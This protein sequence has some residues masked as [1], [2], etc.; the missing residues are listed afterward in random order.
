M[1]T[2]KDKLIGVLGAGPVGTILA[3][4]LTSQGEQVA[5]VEAAGA[6]REQLE[7]S[8]LVVVGEQP[9]SCRPA[10][11][12]GSLEELEGL[13][14][15]ALFICTKTWV[16]R[17][18]LEPLAEVIGPETLIV[19]FQNGIGPEEDVSRSFSVKQVAR[20]VVN[21]AGNV[22]PDTGEANLI[23]FN[24]P[25]YLGA[26]D[27]GD[28]GDHPRL[29]RLTAV[30]TAAGLD[31][32]A[33]STADVKKRAFFKSILNA[34]LMPLCAS[35]GLTM[36]Q[37]MTYAHTR[38]LAR[39][40]LCEGLAVGAALG[41]FYGEDALE[42]GMRYL[43]AGGDHRPSMWVDLQN[44]THTEIEYINGKICQLGRMFK[45]LDVSANR[46]LTSTIA[47]LEILAGIREP[48][49]LPDYLIHD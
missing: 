18:I 46:Y 30:M 16:L 40:V 33:V 34:A 11:V 49:D 38:S 22:D 36:K 32:R 27:H 44:N 37:A 47:T 39:E 45:G 15:D 8:G 28:D 29:E 31:T 5:V 42:Q 41:Y 21:Y 3:A 43:D 20:G 6:R 24:A 2:P 1:D 14:L 35:T 9:R 48:E 17:H 12:L 4:A 26:L 23:W 25:N 7:Q 19:A 13:A 10:A